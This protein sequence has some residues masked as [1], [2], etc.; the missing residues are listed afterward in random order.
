MPL[1]EEE[2]RARTLDVEGYLPKSIDREQLVEAIRRI[3]AGERAFR[4]AEF[5][6]I[7]VILSNREL[8]VLKYLALGKTRD[9]IAIILGLSFHTVKSHVQ[10]I[11][12]RFDA[13]NTTAAVARAY[14]LGVL[15]R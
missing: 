5:T 13:C 2:A 14:E 8:E 15:V 12:R 11:M 1:K 7:P 9:E 4:T 3:A 6:P 10:M